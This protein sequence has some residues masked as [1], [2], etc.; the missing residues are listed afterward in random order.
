L[1]LRKEDNT[2]NIKELISLN[3]SQ[4]TILERN[5]K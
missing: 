4:D 5:L 3:F 2:K 1:T